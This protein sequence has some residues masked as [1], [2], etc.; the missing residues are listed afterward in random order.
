MGGFANPDNYL[1]FVDIHLICS[2]QP[3]D[4]THSE[5]MITY[6][7]VHIILD[8]LTDPHGPLKTML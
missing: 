8:F 5:C 3:A 4:R 1:L 7:V 6:S 2:V